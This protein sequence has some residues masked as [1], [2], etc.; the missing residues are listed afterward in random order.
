MVRQNRSHKDL[1]ES[2]LRAKE[3][4]LEH[5]LNRHQ[6]DLNSNSTNRKRSDKQYEKQSSKFSKNQSFQSR[7]EVLRLQ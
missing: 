4:Q 3:Q 5:L 7:K 6:S 1:R 2:E